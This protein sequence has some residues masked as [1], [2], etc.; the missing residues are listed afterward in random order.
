MLFFALVIITVFSVV[1]AYALCLTL[2]YASAEMLMVPQYVVDSYGFLYVWTFTALTLILV[3]V[4][5]VV[6]IF[7]LF[8]NRMG[9]WFGNTAIRVL[10]FA[11][12]TL[13]FSTPCYIIGLL[14]SK[15]TPYLLIISYGAF[16][17]TLIHPP[18]ILTALSLSESAALNFYIP[19]IIY[20]VSPWVFPFKLRKS[21]V[22]AVEITKV[23]ES[24][25]ER[26]RPNESEEKSRYQ[27]F[28]QGL[29][30]KGDI[31]GFRVCFRDEVKILLLAKAKNEGQLR[32]KLLEIEAYFS[33]HFQ[34][35]NTDICIAN[36]YSLIV[37]ENVA[38]AQITGS[39]RS[40]ANPLQSLAEFFIKTGYCG[41]YL[42]VGKGVKPSM[43]RAFLFR[44]KYRQLVKD[45]EGQE[46]AAS[47]YVDRETSRQNVDYLAQEG[48]EET[49]S[50]LKRLH[51]KRLLKTWTYVVVS[52]E[53]KSE[54]KSVV[55]SA[56]SVLLG[57]LSSEKRLHALKVDSF[58]GKWA[59]SRL[60]QLKP[61]GRATLLR[62]SEAVPFYWIPQ[63]DLGI[64]LTRAAG[65]K[66]PSTLKGELLL[67]N[68]FRNEEETDKEARVALSSLKKHVFIAG[69]TGSGKTNTCLN[70]LIQLHRHDIP[71]LIIEPV[72]GEYRGLKQAL[73]DLR[74][75]T[76]GDEQIAPFRINPFDVP[77]SVKVQTHID[78]LKAV[79]KASYVMYAPMPYVLE[80]CL[81]NVYTKNGW[82]TLTNSRGR[83][84]TLSD[85]YQEIET[86]CRSL[87]Y[88]PK[89]IMDVEAAL[90][91]RIRNLMSG[92]KGI[93]LNTTN[94]IP[95]KEL[96]SYPTILELKSI[97]DDEEKAL[98]MGLILAKVHEYLEAQGG[99]QKLKHVTVIEEAHHLLA[100]IATDVGDPE[101]ADPRRKVVQQL[102]NMLS[103][104]RAYG[105]GIVI[106]EQIP[107]KIIPDAIK[108]TG[109]KIAHRILAEDDR[110]A[111]G[112]T[113]CLSDEQ[114]DALTSLGVGEAVI[115][116]DEY[117]FPFKAKIND[118]ARIHGIRIGE[119]R[120]EEIQ[121]HMKLYYQL[122][123]ELKAIETNCPLCVNQ[124]KYRE[125][126]RLIVGR[127]E[128]E[129]KFK[130]NASVWE[131]DPKSL[132]K[133]LLQYAL[134]SSDKDVTKAVGLAHCLLTQASQQYLTQ[135]PEDSTR[136][137]TFYG[138]FFQ[139]GVE[140]AKRS[141][142]HTT[143]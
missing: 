143:Q 138:R 26:I 7:C 56:S 15:L 103:E 66:T 73:P 94:A 77:E 74:I 135:S 88:E 108:N 110:D 112:A 55:E 30:L 25:L 80:E 45:A 51:S 2:I 57:S 100:N 49:V 86:V 67:G 42:V 23:P 17:L 19:T 10:A 140:I 46:S 79:F 117:P 89:I 63:M 84:P 18:W 3:S 113:M 8:M 106:I 28:L 52:A 48:L 24:F 92:A 76:L 91:T 38:V 32:G 65:F 29:C 58:G 14:L 37:E 120:D 72:K 116:L 139:K 134:N 31:F 137:L 16:L 6:P 93:M 102:A 35:F 60:D 142:Q 133:L 136:L 34:G 9:K 85:L 98:I 21:V 107:T 114:K 20:H 131:S 99:T 47:L 129:E 121:R 69:A 104:V 123:P 111:L 75:F 33:S 101:A 40:V 96:L 70:L 71:F 124:C 125:A 64:K 90:K 95:V 62:P 59:G 87:G 126:A 1:A 127:R 43:L 68:I 83:T 128:F 122:H 97:G 54:A 81:T 61:F 39:P 141:R 11:G 36:D 105:E 13:A 53:D 82:N 4:G 115:S 22:G 50:V 5:F 78:N 27:R 41:D 119:T 12:K 118:A 130:E 132:A 44:R 109:T